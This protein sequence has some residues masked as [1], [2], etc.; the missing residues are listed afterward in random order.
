MMP[1]MA[2]ILLLIYTTNGNRLDL[3]HCATPAAMFPR[4]AAI[5]FLI[6]TTNGSHL[7]RLVAIL[8]PPALNSSR[9]DAYGTNGSHYDP[10]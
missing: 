9:H 2:A 5:L 3:N 8:I 1:R 4:M 7:G 10:N 6:Y